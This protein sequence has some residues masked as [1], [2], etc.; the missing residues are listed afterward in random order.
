MRSDE[1]FL[2]VECTLQ[3]AWAKGAGL[4]DEEFERPMIA[5]VAPGGAVVKA[6]GVGREMWDAV[7]P[8]RV[9]ED[10]ESAIDALRGNA[11]QPGTC[12][13][14][15]NEGTRGGPGM[16]EML[17]ATSALR[18]PVWGATARLSPTDA[19]PA[20]PTAPPSDTSPRRRRAVGRLR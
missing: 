1:Q 20:P 18:G 12:I 11:I 17:G 2:G 7:L 8:A 16:R 4:I 13:V 19:S 15:R 5:V 9:F 14:I 6:S 10:E 3:R